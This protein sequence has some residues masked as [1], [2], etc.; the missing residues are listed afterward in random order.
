MKYLIMVRDPVKRAFSHFR[1]YRVHKNQTDPSMNFEPTADYF[2]TYIEKAVR[3]FQDCLFSQPVE[4]AITSCANANRFTTEMIIGL[5]YV[6]LRQ[7]LTL[8]DTE[9]HRDV[10]VTR[11]EDLG[12][13]DAAAGQELNRMYVHMAVVCVAAFCLGGA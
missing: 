4:L 7:W 8:S 6:H 11:L 10:L 9:L 3:G 1:F 13:Q 12:G 2:H 5:Y